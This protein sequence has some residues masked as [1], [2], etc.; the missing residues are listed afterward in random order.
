[1]QPPQARS[2]LSGGTLASVHAPLLY[3]SMY[4]QNERGHVQH[5]AISSCRRGPADK[6]F[7]AQKSAPHRD[8]YNVRKVDTHVH[9]RQGGRRQRREG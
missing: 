7:L 1:M 8:F 6:E 5:H 4:P 9:H 2:E 3:P